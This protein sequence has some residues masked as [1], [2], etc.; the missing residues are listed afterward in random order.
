MAPG[1]SPYRISV[2]RGAAVAADPLASIII[3]VTSDTT[4]L[5]RCLRSVAAT[6]SS[7]HPC[8]VIVVANG[9]PVRAA[10]QLGTRDDV[11]VL[12]S[13]VNHG[14]AGGCNLAARCARGDRLVFLNDDVAVTAGWLDGLHQALDRDPK[15]AVVG[16]KVV[17]SDGRLQEA[18][19]VLWR[20]GST[21]GAGRGG[22]P[23]APEFSS[24]RRVDYV[25]FCSAM[26]RRTAWQE[27]GGFD[28]RYFPAYYEDVDLCLTLHQLGWTVQYEPS[29]IVYHDEGGSAS[30]GYRSFL[31][32]R[33][34]AMFVAK[35]AHVIARYDPPPARDADLPRA[36]EHA[37]RS[38]AERPIPSRTEAG[39]P[40]S[41]DRVVVAFDDLEAL[42]VEVRHLTAAVAVDADYIRAVQAEASRRGVLDVVISRVRPR[43]AQIKKRLQQSARH[44]SKGRR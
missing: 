20:D 22:A 31:S 41:A 8:E 10:D 32:T 38:T 13:P 7:D 14:F 5:Q 21:S 27:A 25:S 44:V 37:L 28:E 29:S 36:V 12:R 1:P 23:E 40:W 39:R 24:A 6:V 26:V 4:K 17:L 16:S 2:H 9:T 43:L 3:L 34:Q 18:G 11:I 33:N 35:W 19:C 15:V 30:P 42:A